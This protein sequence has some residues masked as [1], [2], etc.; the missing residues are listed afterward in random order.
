MSAT[1]WAECPICENKKIEDIEKLNKSY[2]VVDKQTYEKL[3][4][5][6]D[7]SSDEF[8]GTPVREDYEIG[9]NDNGTLYIIYSGFCQNCG[10]E[11]RFDKRDI[12]RV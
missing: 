12:K 8:D 6:M 7:K 10:A 2:G 1:N 9:L 3:K 4:E 11:W 5:E